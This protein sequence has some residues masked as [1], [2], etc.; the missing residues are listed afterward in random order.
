MFT[1]QGLRIKFF[2]LGEPARIRGR[3]FQVS[4]THIHEPV[5]RIRLTIG[6]RY[7][8]PNA[9]GARAVYAHPRLFLVAC[10]RLKINKC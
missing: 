3:S 6:Y 2:Y 8:T 5:V 10:N 4:Q 7:A 9:V 1:R